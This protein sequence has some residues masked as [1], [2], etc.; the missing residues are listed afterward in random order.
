MSLPFPSLTPDHIHP[1]LVNF[2][3]ALVPA[4]VVSDAAGRILRKP[5]LHAAAWWMLI[6]ATAL[7]PL[8]ALAGLWW[9]QKL[10]DTLPADQVA[11]H[12]WIGIGLTVAFIVLLLWRRASYRKS[13]APGLA[14][15]A[16]A[17]L[18]IAALLIQGALG[19]NMVFGG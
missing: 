10:R 3:S 7:T 13:E 8:T 16:F 4:S 2:T 11:E 15:F 17:I 18:I 9:K 5:A 6:Y 14:Y 12:M 19:G 1:I